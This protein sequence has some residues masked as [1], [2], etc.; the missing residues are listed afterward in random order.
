MSGT[1]IIGLICM[2]YVAG[3]FWLFSDTP[4]SKKLRILMWAMAVLFGAPVLIKIWV[5]GIM[6]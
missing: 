6:G 5:M 1:E 3:M 2:A 4:K